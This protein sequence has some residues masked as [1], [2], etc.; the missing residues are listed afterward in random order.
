MTEA[1]RLGQLIMA[2]VY[3][4]SGGAVNSLI[5][6]RHVGAVLLLGEGWWGAT[7]V[8]SVCTDLQQ[9]AGA[10]PLLIAVDQEGGRVQH[11]RGDGFDAMPSALA[12]G[13]LEASQLRQQAEEWG[14]QLLSAGVNVDLAPVVDVVTLPN[15]GDN[16]PIGRMERSFAPG[17]DA[18]LVGTQATAFIEGM[19]QAGVGSAIKHFPGLGAVAANTDLAS[20]G[21]TDTTTTADGASIQAFKL[22]LAAEPTMVMVSHA[23]YT[24]LDPAAPAV[25]SEVVVTDLLRGTL[26][27][28]GVVISDSLGAAAV[29]RVPVG[30]RATRFVAAGGDL[31]IYNTVADATTGLDALVAAAAASPEFSQRADQAALRVLTAKAQLGL[32]D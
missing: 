22:A 28:D 1:E 25:F 4:N 13:Q 19:G 30:E 15:P 24:L 5:Q 16:A 10:T 20:Q 18:E 2:T 6:D 29:Q 7:Q 23:T 3:A 17:A 11:L 14:G 26:G 12:Q 27:W 32:L 31:A 8:L 21:I 9:L